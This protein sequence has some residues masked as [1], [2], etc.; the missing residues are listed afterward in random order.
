[1][2]KLFPIFKLSVWVELSFVSFFSAKLGVVCKNSVLI[3]V[4][5]FWND[6]NPDITEAV[7]WILFVVNSSWYIGV[8]VVEIIWV[9]TFVGGWTIFV[10]SFWILVDLP[11]ISSLKSFW[12]YFSWSEKFSFNGIFSWTEETGSLFLDLTLVDG[13][14]EILKFAELAEICSKFWFVWIFFPSN[15][16]NISSVW[17]IF[18]ISTFVV[19]VKSP[20][21]VWKLNSTLLLFKLESISNVIF[22]KSLLVINSFLPESIGELLSSFFSTTTNSPLLILPIFST[23]LNPSNDVVLRESWLILISFTSV[24][25][26]AFIFWTF[27]IASNFFTLTLGPFSWLTWIFS[28]ENGSKDAVLARGSF[29]F[30][31]LTNASFLELI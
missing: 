10:I 30:K 15:S 16:D 2:T 24:V 26:S 31:E 19:S 12:K 14:S 8:W 9:W 13:Y 29:S 25:D 1:M 21:L 6:S 27:S 28:Y 18:F 5:T 4:S 3:F 23:V 22:A 11:I 20:M 17:V 7:G